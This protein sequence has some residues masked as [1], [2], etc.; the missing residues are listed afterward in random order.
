M[1]DVEV[2]VADGEVRVFGGHV[3]VNGVEGVGA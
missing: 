1:V 2:R 3:E